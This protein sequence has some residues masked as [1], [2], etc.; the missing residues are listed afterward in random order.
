MLTT[1]S[2][3]ACFLLFSTPL[4]AQELSMQETFEKIENAGL[5][6][7]FFAMTSIEPPPSGELILEGVTV[8]NNN[9]YDHIAGDGAG[10]A[11]IQLV[12]GSIFYI[13]SEGEAAGISANLEDLLAVGLSMYSW[14]DALRYI[15]GDLEADRKSWIL[16]REEWRIP[17]APEY[18]TEAREILS[19]LGIDPVED[20]F[21]MLHEAVTMNKS[22]KVQDQH[23]DLRDFTR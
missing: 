6:E 7:P 14:A 10:G 1:I 15:Q 19:L 16:F 12:D 11:F 2:R 21:S 9:N 20:P 8:Q 17:A 3:L 18:P 5:I 23:G 22:I 13:S 4:I